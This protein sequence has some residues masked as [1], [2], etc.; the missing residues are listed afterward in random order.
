MKQ[1]Y[2]SQ[3]RQIVFVHPRPD[4]E[5]WDRLWENA[6][7]Q[8]DKIVAT[9]Q[10]K[11]TRIVGRYLKPGDGKILEGGCGP[12]EQVASLVNAGFEVIGID[13]APKTVT[14]ALANLP[15]LDIREADIC[16]LPFE[17]NSFAG[18]LSL[19]VIEHF[20]RGYEEAAAEMARV[21]RDGGFLFLAFPYMSPIRRLKGRTGQYP[22]VENLEPGA[23]FQYALDHKDVI[24]K[25]G[26]KGFILR[27]VV[28]LDP[29]NGL[30]LEWPF[31][32]RFLFS[33]KTNTVSRVLNALL[34]RSLESWAS[35]SIM[36]VFQKRNKE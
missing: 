21:I 14:W 24:A 23:F 17:D 19:G 8:A 4:P 32:H 15:S 18:Y 28:R 7:F 10:T 27:E 29:D 20:E 16:R 22:V 30:R 33:Q 36:L 31:L 11:F 25:M 6:R 12:G 13:T 9:S 5:Y 2:C 1:L 35:H 26:A 34:G 3:S